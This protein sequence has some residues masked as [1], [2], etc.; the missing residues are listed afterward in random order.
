MHL[1]K[2]CFL[3]EV[4]L[5]DSFPLKYRLAWLGLTGLARLGACL[6]IYQ[7]SAKTHFVW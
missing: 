2:V 3:K 1:N 5:S 4:A 6:H 7:V